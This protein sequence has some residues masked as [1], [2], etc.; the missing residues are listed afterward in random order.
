MKNKLFLIAIVLFI[1]S[2]LTNA[3]LISSYGIKVG[4]AN[5]SQSWNYSGPLSGLEVFNK[6]RV[7]LDLGIYSEWFNLP[8]I[9]MLTEIHY[10]QKGCKGEFVVSTMNNPDGT[11]EMKT[12]TPRIDYISIPLLAKIRYNIKSIILYGIA[13]PRLDILIGKNSDATGAVLD[14]LKKTDFGGTFG[15][16]F[17]LLLKKTYRI[18]GE[19]RYSFSSQYI[20]SNRWLNVKNKSLEFLLV[21]GL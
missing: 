3:Q 21:F 1:F 19:F 13:G 2:N 6:S 8:I 14:D 17:E 12:S 5:T 9:S 20:Y 7:G 16:G 18:G 10:I 4:M 11:G 15:I